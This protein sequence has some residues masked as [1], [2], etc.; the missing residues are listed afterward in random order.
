MSSFS[1]KRRA[2]VIKVSEADDADAENS[3][4]S[5]NDGSRQEAPKPLFGFK[6]GRKPFR[7]SGLRKSFTPTDE[8]A[9]EIGQDANLAQDDACVVIRPSTMKQKKKMVKSRLSFGLGAGDASDDHG[10]SALAS[11]SQR[12]SANIPRAGIAI[13]EL[14][15]R[16]IPEDLDRPIYSKE[17]LSELQSSTPN[18]PGDISSMP[19]DVDEMMLDASELQGATIVDASEA[20]TSVP[21]TQILSE[22]EIRER[23]ERRARLAKE[24][25]YIVIDDDDGDNGLGRSKKETTRLVREE[26]DLGEGFDDYVEDGGLA[27]GKRAEKERRRR[28]RRQMAE[29]INTAEGHSSESSSES[30]AER[31]MAYEAAQ[32]R[33]GLDGIEKPGKSTKD[34]NVQLPSKFLPLPSLPECLA[35]LQASLKSMEKDIRTKHASIEQLRREREEVDRREAEVQ[36]LLDETGRKYQEAMSHGALSGVQGSVTGSNGEFTTQRGLESIGATPIRPDDDVDIS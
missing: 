1:A 30:D 11:K 23:K 20:M 26:E 10:D 32:T 25:E 18:T 6:A 8:N 36:A 14:P 5:E 9:A 2:R 12:Q 34:I 29:L 28:H 31:R 27:L 24:Q 4:A 7:Q 16:V 33:A 15:P 13:R 35:R 3:S 21:N 22:A 17:Y 19:T